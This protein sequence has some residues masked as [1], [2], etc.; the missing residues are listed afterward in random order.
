MTGKYP[1]VAEVVPHK[2]P[3][4]LLDEILDVTGPTLRARVTLTSQSPFVEDGQVAVLVTIEYMAQ[5]IAAFA[6]LTRRASG[7]PVI[8]GYLIACREMKLELDFL[9]VG[10]ELEVAVTQIWHDEKLGNFDCSVT[11]GREKVS[12]AWLSV[13]QG[14]LPNEA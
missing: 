5:A 4:I 6:G 1:P 11:R 9:S 7:Q 12:Q 8:L 2:A 10:D 13:Y 14:D 3:M